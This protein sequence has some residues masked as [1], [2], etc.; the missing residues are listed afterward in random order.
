MLQCDLA[1]LHLTRAA[2]RARGWSSRTAHA[3]LVSGADGQAAGA[4][5]GQQGDSWLGTE[6][7]G[8]WW[9]KAILDQHETA[10]NEPPFRLYLQSRGNGHKVEYRTKQLVVDSN[11][12]SSTNVG[13]AHKRQRL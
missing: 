7:E 10:P 12:S 11:E 4:T 3:A 2:E 13:T 1:R 9:T 6:E 5:D 8:G